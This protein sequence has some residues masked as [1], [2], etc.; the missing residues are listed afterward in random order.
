[1]LDRRKEDRRRGLATDRIDLFGDGDDDAH[2]VF[3][4]IRERKEAFLG[5]LSDAARG[6]TQ[7]DNKTRLVPT[8]TWGTDL[9]G[10]PDVHHDLEAGLNGESSGGHWD[11]R[12]ADA[13]SGADNL[14]CQASVVSEGEAA[15]KGGVEI[16]RALPAILD[17]PLSV[18]GDVVMSHRVLELEAAKVQRDR[19]S[20]AMKLTSW[21]A[22]AR[23]CPLGAAPV[24]RESQTSSMAACVPTEG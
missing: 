1:M 9:V 4:Q 13:R 20:S 8:E 17:D 7:S 23:V 21:M 22:S 3:E 24:L 19:S 2:G 11:E 15:L 18:L 12:D 16:E 6:A 5:Q 10:R 14:P